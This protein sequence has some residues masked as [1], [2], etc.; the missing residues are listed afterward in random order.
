MKLVYWS[1]AAA[2]L[3]L[4]SC[5]QG[6][7]GIFASIEREQ[8]IKSAGG[9]SKVAT[10]THMA[11]LNGRYYIAG[12]AA[13][14]QR[15]S[16]EAK[17]HPTEDLPAGYRQVMSVGRAGDVTT[18][19]LY[20][21]ANQGSTAT[22]ALL[23]YNGTSWSVAALPD[24][25]D[26]AFSLVPIHSPDGFTSDRLLLTVTPNSA[27]SFQKAYIIDS[28]GFQAT[29]V[30]FGFAY[31]FPATGAA[32]DGTSGY[33]IA[34]YDR[35]FYFN[36]ATTAEVTGADL[37]PAGGATADAS[38]FFDVILLPV[39]DFG[40]WGGNPA[41]VSSTKSTLYWGSLNAGVWTQKAKLSGVKDEGNSAVL[42]GPMIYQD[43]NAT[44]YVWIGTLN[45]TVQTV[46][47]N[48]G[49]G[50]ASLTPA[51]NAQFA[52]FDLQPPKG[53]D[54]D[55]YNSSLLPLSQVWSMTRTSNATY[56]A[57]TAAQGLWNWKS[58][59][60]EWSQE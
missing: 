4:A 39:A 21:V 19:V 20:A 29:A 38:G 50:F 13:L 11:E 59:T 54:K 57:G 37:Q 48:Q 23:S 43:Q 51:A 46:S 31:G 34:N 40:T 18:G 45:A 22:N 56:Y 6:S 25:S 12:G 14:F 3:V 17:W 10:V 26:R 33:Y 36:G 55:N 8:K 49:A 53:T 52:E 58:T 1:A 44:K 5:T 35:V 30:D 27:N 42:F 47:T 32:F 24:T 41:V 15:S 16:T 28:G 60:L 2:L 7:Q 9:L